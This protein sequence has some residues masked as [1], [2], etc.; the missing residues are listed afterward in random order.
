M[1]AIMHEP[2]ALS[3]DDVTDELAPSARE[4]AEVRQL[5]RAV[6]REECSVLLLDYDGTLAP[7]TTDRQQAFP[8]E[9]V[10]MLLEEIMRSGRTRVGIV[11]GRTAHE[12][13]FFLGT[14]P[15][16]EVWGSHGLQRLRPDGRCEMPQVD[17]RVSMGLEEAGREVEKQGLQQLVEFKPG[18]VAVH[19]RGLD[20]A[21]AREVHEKALEAWTPLVLKE[22]LSLLEFDG[23]LEIRIAGLDKGDAVRTILDEVGPHAP[24]AYLG[25]DVT[26]ERAFHALGERGLSILVRPEWRKTRAQLWLRP[27][28]DVLDFLTMW[29]DATCE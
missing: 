3:H 12:V 21:L 22:R 23:G 19:W 28:G 18:G 11:T 29:R 8:Y 25:D 9:G 15:I 2:S 17:R 16:P 14:E 5:M 20:E 1:N 10:A 6:E 13:V 27:P 26:D 7:F 24:I 4:M